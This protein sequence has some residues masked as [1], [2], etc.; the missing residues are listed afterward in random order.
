MTDLRTELLEIKLE[1]RV[2]GILRLSTSYFVQIHFCFS[3]V[4]VKHCLLQVNSHG[5]FLNKEA[6]DKFMDQI[7]GGMLPDFDQLDEISF[8]ASTSWIL[9]SA[10]DELAKLLPNPLGIKALYQAY[11]SDHPYAYWLPKP[12]KQKQ[13]SLPSNVDSIPAIYVCSEPPEVAFFYS[14]V[15][16]GILVR[17]IAGKKIKR[18]IRRSSLPDDSLDPTERI[19]GSA[20]NAFGFLYWLID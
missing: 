5:Q 7:D 3:K 19:S 9:S 14:K 2:T 12:I 11:K 16:A 8:D 18:Q 1:D 13:N 20:A 10:F 17:L 6:I 15:A 4:S